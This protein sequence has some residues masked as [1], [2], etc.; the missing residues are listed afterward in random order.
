MRSFVALHA[1]DFI[2]ILIPCS[3]LCPTRNVFRDRTVRDRERSR[4]YL[5]DESERMFLLYINHSIDPEIAFR[6]VNILYCSVYSFFFAAVV[7][8]SQ[9]PWHFPLF[10]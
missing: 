2:F 7:V 5:E 1:S 4:C 9:I 3:I 6:P 8:S 10:T